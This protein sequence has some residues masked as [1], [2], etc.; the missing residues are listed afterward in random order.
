MKNIF[1]IL[2]FAFST[3][4]FAQTPEKMNYQAIV[5]NADGNLVSNATVGLQISILKTSSTS[6]KPRMVMRKIS[7][8]AN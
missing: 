8:A 7:P 4:V 6:S 3:I 2:A 5:R 1:L